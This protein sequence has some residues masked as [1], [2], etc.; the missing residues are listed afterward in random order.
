MRS[1]FVILAAFAATANAFSPSELK[2][3]FPKKLSE[4]ADYAVSVSA[5]EHTLELAKGAKVYDIN[6]P[7]FS[8]YALKLRTLWVPPKTKVMYRK[9][10]PFD[11]PVGTVIAKTFYFPKNGALSGQPREDHEK[12]SGFV[13]GKFS[14]K[15]KRLLE[16]R[17]LIKTKSEWVG[18]PY[19]WNEEQTDAFL[20]IAGGRI[21]LATLKPDQKAGTLD[22]TVP[23][24]NQCKECHGRGA[25][26]EMFPIGLQ[27]RHL[28]RHEQL[29]T[30]AAV[31][32]LSGL[33]PKPAQIPRS[34]VWNDTKSG[35][36]DSRARAYLDINCGH[37]HNAQ[38][39][40]RT[41]GLYLSSDITDPE[42]L[43]VRKAPVASGIGSGN[44][45]F[46]IVPGSPDQSILV[47]RMAS[48]TPK[49]VMPEIG[50]SLV[51]EEGLALIREW[52]SQLK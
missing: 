5:S 44:L 25:E 17:L 7:L 42:T 15:D 27:A 8:D 18:L 49:V 50:R 46:D 12:V 41:T 31:K 13:D 19:I 28:N 23:N 20:E 35:S 3:P 36:L 30:W 14:L 33:P 11:F 22:Y 2:R 34:A 24:M 47:Y 43:G 39:A 52:V 48:T 10:E 45:Y 26:M 6:T 21:S 9:K 1:V 29:E 4:W 32:L 37:C 40:A 16:T 51:H 38:G